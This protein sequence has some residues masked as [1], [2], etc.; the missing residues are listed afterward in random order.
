MNLRK[1]VLFIVVLGFSLLTLSFYFIARGI[2]MHKFSSLEE[3]EVIRNVSRALNGL[4]DRE[5]RLNALAEDWAW[6]DEMYSFVKHPTESFEKSNFVPSTFYS[7]QI[8]LLVVYNSQGELVEGRIWKDKELEDIPPNL[9]A[10][11]YQEARVAKRT[12]PV[13]KTGLVHLDN[14]PLLVSYKPV[15][16]SGLKG[17]AQGLFA[18]AMDMRNIL[19]ELARETE[20]DLQLLLIP[21]QKDEPR[22]KI[23]DQT[24]ETLVPLYDIGGQPSMQL[25]LSMRRGFYIAGSEAAGLM[26]KVFFVLAF[27]LSALTLLFLDRRILR[28]IETLSRQVTQIG[29]REGNERVMLTGKDELASLA[30]DINAMLGELQDHERYLAQILDSLQVGVVIMDPVDC[31]IQYVNSQALDIW[32]YAAASDGESDKRY[33][34][35]CEAY[36]HPHEWSCPNLTRHELDLPSGRRSLLRNIASLK[37]GERELLLHTF[38]DITELEQTQ[39]ALALSEETY[40]T[41]FFNTGA[42]NIILSEEKKIVQANREFLNLVMADSQ[43]DVLGAL[44]TDYVH[45]E[46]IEGL[47]RQY[48]QRRFEGF[49]PQSYETSLL[50]GDGNVVHVL[51]TMAS[52]PDER[53]VIVSFADITNRKKV[54]LEMQRVIT[55][56]E[57][58]SRAKSEFLANMSHEIR[59]P[60]NGVLGMLQILEDTQLDEEQQECV[61][62]AIYSGKSLLTVINDILDFS[63]IEAGKIEII[64]ENFCLR[65]LLESVVG[66]FQGPASAK[67]IALEYFVDEDVPEFV[68][69]DSARVRQVLFNIVGN[70]LKFT[71]SGSVRLYVALPHDGI[72]GDKGSHVLFTVVDSGVGIPKADQHLIFDSFT[73][74]DGSQTRKHQGTGLGLAIVKRLVRLMGGDISVSSAAGHGSVFTFDMTLPAG[75]QPSVSFEKGLGIE[76]RKPQHILVVEDNEVSATTLEKVLRRLGHS[77]IL[78]ETGIEALKTLKKSTFSMVL[79]DVQMPEL[80]GIE[81]TR[82]IRSGE[83]GKDKAEVPIIALTAFAMKGDRERFL[84][85]GMNSYLAKPLSINEVAR[86]IDRFA[87]E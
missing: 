35:F 18:V 83:A 23:Y 29:R 77:C 61:Q 87:S 6:W 54:E 72:R 64:H 45:P 3:L 13:D 9:A 1:T 36:G 85:S 67:G 15:L 40:R 38:V 68:V 48:E 42:P 17:P 4:S 62:T 26:L 52:L 86:E 7:A 39:A 66:L 53:R 30:G 12:G 78:V 32:G 41:I 50:Q 34:L 56:A 74:A 25:R 47:S 75:K 46:D 31:S 59:T 63:K 20:L 57:K 21:S 24:I 5:A 73:Q 76:P 33:E 80:D 19:P 11:L 70:A 79:M 14:F 43:S 44:W 84:A 65:E 10:K 60:L 37:H 82:R 27:L 28:R 22:S 55:A 16:T 69:G 49:P 51:L 71:D 8:Y 81:T 58:A 2:I